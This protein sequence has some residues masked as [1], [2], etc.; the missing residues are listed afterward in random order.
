MRR[1]HPVPSSEQIRR[2]G[3][4]DHPAAHLAAASGNELAYMQYV[5][6]R[7]PEQELSCLLG[8]DRRRQQAMPPRFKKRP[9]PA[10]RRP[11]GEDMLVALVHKAVPPLLLK[12]RHETDVPGCCL[13]RD[14][15]SI[16]IQLEL[17]GLHRE[18][19]PLWCARRPNES[20]QS[21]AAQ[22][23]RSARTISRYR[24]ISDRWPSAG[25]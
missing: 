12:P 18:I 11:H 4:A 9:L 8:S 20:P 2:K 14:R 25:K 3:R 6:A 23:R 22:L 5:A 17:D 24:T 13:E 7:A 19:S 15:G 10:R 16:L 1:P 21:S